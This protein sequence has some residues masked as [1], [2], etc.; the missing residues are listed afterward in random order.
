MVSRSVVYIPHVIACYSCIHAYEKCNHLDFSSMRV[1]ASDTKDPGVEYKIVKC[2]A[3][4]KDTA[5]DGVGCAEKR[6]IEVR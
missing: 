6:G 3:H 4:V 5:K 2:S 1:I